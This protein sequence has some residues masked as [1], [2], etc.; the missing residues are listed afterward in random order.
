MS[1]NYSLSHKNETNFYRDKSEGNAEC[2]LKLLIHK[3]ASFDFSEEVENDKTVAPKKSFQSFQHI[4]L[5]KFT[6]IPVEEFL[7]GS[8]FRLEFNGKQRNINFF[9]EKDSDFKKNKFDINLKTSSMKKSASV[10]EIEEIPAPETSFLL[11]LNKKNKLERH[12]V[13]QDIMGIIFPSDRLNYRENDSE[14]KIYVMP[15]FKYTLELSKDNSIIAEFPIDSS[16]CLGGYLNPWIIFWRFCANV[17]SFPTGTKLE[18]NT[19]LVFESS[20]RSELFIKMIKRIQEYDGNVCL[21]DSRRFIDNT[22]VFIFHSNIQKIEQIKSSKTKLEILLLDLENFLWVEILDFQNEKH[23]QLFYKDK[24]LKQVIDLKEDLI[25]INQNIITFKK[26]RFTFL[27]NIDAEI[28]Y[29]KLLQMGMVNKKSNFSCFCTLLYQQQ[30]LFGKLIIEKYRDQEKKKSRIISFK[31]S[32]SKI[33]TQKAFQSSHFKNHRNSPNSLGYL[34]YELKFINETEKKNFL[35]A[36]YVIIAEE[37]CENAQKFS[38]DMS[39]KISNKF[40][41]K[42][43]D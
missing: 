4:L 21:T 15:D 20:M 6:A 13:F 16:F 9:S 42:I 5:E 30:R 25:E 17:I 14:V 32:N 2:K 7:R 33:I 23:I 31:T 24:C 22:N 19:L 18:K 28:I 29:D 10:Y 39:K 1:K 8:S 37:F 40:N 36:L 41:R 34:N 26:L 38:Q 11:S 12:I 43:K 27:R 35:S 3:T